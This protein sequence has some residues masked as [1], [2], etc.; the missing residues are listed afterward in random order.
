MA[1]T[2][3][4]TVW[5]KEEFDEPVP[6]YA[7]LIKYAKSGMISPPPMKAGKCWRVDK[8]ARFIGM[9]TKPMVKQND[10]PR[11]KRIMEDGQT[12]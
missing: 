5:A 12:S 6:S 3:A 11:L 10:D 9:E 2:Q 4:L 7:T 8:T 1:R